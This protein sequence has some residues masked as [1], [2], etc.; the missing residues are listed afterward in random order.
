MVVQDAHKIFVNSKYW[1][2]IRNVTLI[3]NC[4]RGECIT[5]RRVTFISQSPEQHEN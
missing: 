2:H 1:A 3:I 5:R 4:G